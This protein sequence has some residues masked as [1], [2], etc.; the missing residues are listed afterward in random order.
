[1]DE[2]TMEFVITF[3]HHI[4]DEKPIICIMKWI[5][6]WL[7]IIVISHSLGPFSRAFNIFAIDDS[8]FETLK[9]RSVPILIA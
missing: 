8:L 4:F 5:L 1:M 2:F 3:L 7:K 6:D 9:A